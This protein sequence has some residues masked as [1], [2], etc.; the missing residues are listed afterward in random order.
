MFYKILIANRGEVAVRILGACRELGI[1]TVAVYSEADAHA[2]HV[3]LADEAVC[4]GP[5]AAAQSYLNIPSIM[6]AAEVT[7]AEAVHPGYGFLSENAHFAEICAKC[8]VTF[9]GPSPDAMHTWGDKVTAR[10]NAERLGLPLLPGS[11]V[12]ESAHHAIEEAN[13][14]G[15]PVLLKAAGGGG[16]RGMRVVRTA[17]QMEDAFASASR[18]AE[19]GFKN[20]SLYVER[21]IEY[22]KHI[23]FQI[24]ADRHQGIWV[25][26]ERECSLQRRHQKVM[27]EATSPVMTSENRQ[28]MTN[29]ILKALNS[30]SYESL[31]TLEFVMDEDQKLY[32]L[33]MNTRLQVEHPVTELVTGLDLV[34]LQ[35]RIAAGEKLNLSE[36]VSSSFQGHAIECRINA[37]DPKTFLPSPGFIEECFLPGGIGIRVDSGVCGGWRVPPYYDSLLAKLIVHA[38]T[39]QEA[40]IRMRRALSECSIRGIR[41]NIELHQRLLEMEEV[42][43][44]RMTTRTIE[45]LLAKG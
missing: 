14:I 28:Q 8:G 11:Q 7:G 18:E 34:A 41:T 36:I 23:E 16:G 4:I 38:P 32:F 15:F 5:G 9:I 27:E 10:R 37:E 42:I 22:P 35:I 33:E 30:T 31:G 20:P 2:L 21:L 43:E 40:I 44:G 25:L 24:I 13:R 45:N 1:K 39:R 3:R 17:A 6:S 19:I 26:G 12:L 29:Q